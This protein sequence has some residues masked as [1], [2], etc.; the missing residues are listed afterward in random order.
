MPSAVAFLPWVAIDEPI[1]VGPLRLLPYHRSKLPGDLQNATQTDIDGVLD[2]YANRPRSKIKKATIF[3]LGEWQTGM[4]ARDIV[5]ALFRARNALAFA[6]LA[7]RQLFRQHSGYCNYDTYTLN[8]QRYAPGNP[9]TFAF[10]TRRRDGG[11]NQLWSTN[12]FAFHRPNHVDAQ[13]RLSVDQPLL[14]ALLSLSSPSS[15]LLESVIEFNCANTDSPDVPDHVEVVMMKSAFEWLLEI[16]E[17]AND[18][19]AGLNR[20]LQDIPPADALNGPLKAQWEKSRPK[21]GRPLEAWAREFCDMRG[22]SAHGKPRVAPRF[23]WTPH[24]HLAF[25]S[26][27]FPLVFKKVAASAG[28]LKLDVYDVERLRRI[29]AYLLHEPFTFDWRA[30]NSTHPWVEMDFRALVSAQSRQFYEQTGA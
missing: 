16:G 9:G 13:A 27:L 20:C 23:V 17:Q 8:V 3:E 12:E 10:T 18:F 14:A 4:D 11:T 22:A 25:A 30:D 6:A 28:L 1:T 21:A 15:S 24:T 19:V 5:P 7:H 29:D 2:A 26:L